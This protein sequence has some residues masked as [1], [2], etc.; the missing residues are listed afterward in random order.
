MVSEDGAPFVSELATDHQIDAWVRRFSYYRKP[1]MRDDLLVWLSRFQAKHLEVAHRILDNVTMISE[2]QIHEGYRDGLNELQGWSKKAND[3]EGRWYFV[4][5]G[6][7]GESGPAM[8]RLFREANGLASNNWSNFF[9]SPTDLPSLALSAYDS[10]VFV[11]DFAGTGDQMK[12]YWPI[13]E[14]LIASEAK[15]YLLITAMTSDAETA[16]NSETEFRIKAKMVL[17]R[18]KNVLS[19]ESNLFNKEE[20]AAL[21]SYGKLADATKPFGYGDCGLCVVLS[22]KTPNNSLPILHANHNRWVGMFPRYLLQA[23]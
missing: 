3:R 7:Q 9:V 14:E 4:G 6:G 19:P 1:P 13:V 15:C 10:V 23:Q 22:H 12:N 8:L 17:P 18:S 20:I 11:D 16:I 21:E 2:T 5:V